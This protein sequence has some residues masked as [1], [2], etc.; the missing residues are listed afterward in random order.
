MCLFFSGFSDMPFIHDSL[1]STF[2][3][4]LFIYALSSVVLYPPFYCFNQAPA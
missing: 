1:L 3:V 2:I 4:I